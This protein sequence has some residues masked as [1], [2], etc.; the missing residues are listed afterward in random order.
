[1]PFFYV[2]G[3]HDVTNPEMEKIWE[4]KFGR[5]YY[6]FVY[7]DVLFLILNS[8]D[9]PGTSGLSEAQVE[10]GDA[11][12][13]RQRERALD[14]RGVAQADLDRGH[15]EEPAGAKSKRRWPAGTTRSSPA[16]CTATR[17]SS[18]TA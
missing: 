13:G 15:R 12:A 18:A 10:V 14:D 11:G 6:H 17:S 7:N 8:D 4:E 2:P 9:P 5:R 1:M 3:N 16:T